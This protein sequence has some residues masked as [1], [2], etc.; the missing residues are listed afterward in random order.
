VETHVEKKYLIIIPQNFPQNKNAKNIHNKN[1]IESLST[2]PHDLFIY[3]IY[4]R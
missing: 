2:F 3:I 1:I 4:Y